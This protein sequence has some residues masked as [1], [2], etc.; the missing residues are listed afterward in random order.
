MKL[1]LAI[2]FS[3]SCLAQSVPAVNSPISSWPLGAVP[4]W[5]KITV[6]NSSTNFTVTCAPAIAACGTSPV[7]KAGAMVQSVV[8]VTPAVAFKLTD[9]LVKTGTQFAGPATLTATVGITGTLTGCVSAAYNLEAA[10]SA[11]NFGIPTL[12]TSAASTNGTDSII[13]ALTGATNITN[14]SAGS[15]TVWI[16]LEYLP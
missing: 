3:L 4:V 12:V 14:V 13:L 2:L 16:R 11:T 5:M 10:V 1:L 8:L 9:C 6:T 7:A 15:V